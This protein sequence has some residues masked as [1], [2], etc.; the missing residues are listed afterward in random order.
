MDIRVQGLHL[1]VD[2]LS[3]P[4]VACAVVSPCVTHRDRKFNTTFT[5]YLHHII[6]QKS[7]YV[8]TRGSLGLLLVGPTSMAGCVGDLL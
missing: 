4:L 1:D 6:L 7:Y 3:H 2:E 8:V 5:I